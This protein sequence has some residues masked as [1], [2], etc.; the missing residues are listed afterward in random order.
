M[1]SIVTDG[2]SVNIGER[3]GLRTLFQQKWRSLS[4]QNVPL[5]II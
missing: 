2:A 1:S 5:I 4:E 3:G